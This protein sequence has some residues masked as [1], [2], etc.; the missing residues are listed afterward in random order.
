MNTVELLHH[1]HRASSASSQ[2]LGIYEHCLHLI[3]SGSLKISKQ[4]IEA[5]SCMYI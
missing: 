1:N 4:S 3:G 2:A 5:E